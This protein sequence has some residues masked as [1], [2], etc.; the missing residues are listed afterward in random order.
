MYS[1]L[2]WSSSLRSFSPSENPVFPQP[3]PKLDRRRGFSNRAT[4]VVFLT[5]VINFILSSLN[6]GTLVAGFVAPI[7]KVLILDNKYLLPEMVAN[8]PWN[9]TAVRIWAAN[10]SV[11]ITELSLSDPVSKVHAR[12]RHLS[13]IS[14]LF[15]GLGPSSRISSG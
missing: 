13:V 12:W 2:H 4:V 15:G 7:R 14:L 5:T 10:L 6:T 8:A 11:S 1:L 9:V 3:A